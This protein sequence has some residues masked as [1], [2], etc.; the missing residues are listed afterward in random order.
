M[1]PVTFWKIPVD[2]PTPI[3]INAIVGVADAIKTA[4]R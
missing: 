1:M 2:I 4:R 3:C